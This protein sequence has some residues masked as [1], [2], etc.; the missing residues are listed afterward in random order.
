MLDELVARARQHTSVPWND[1]RERRLLTGALELAGRKARRHSIQRRVTLSG[2]ALVLLSVLVIAFV[3]PKSAVA[4]AIANHLE[5]PGGATAEVSAGAEVRVREVVRD[6]V[7]VLQSR[8]HVTYEVARDPDR[9]FE[10]DAADVRVIVHG[11]RFSVTVDESWVRVAVAT[12]RVE[13]HDGLR[14]TMLTNG[15]EIRV[16]GYVAAASATQATASAVPGLGLAAPGDA[17]TTEPAILPAPPTAAPR[18]SPETAQLLLDRADSARRERRFAEAASALRTLVTRYP[19]DRRAAAAWFTLGRI[20]SGRGNA[21]GAADAFA[22]CRRI[23]RGPLAEDALAEEAAARSSATLAREYL[24]DY[25]N[26]THRKRM[27]A[28]VAR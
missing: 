15:E 18:A 22:S 4:P 26:G 3:Q 25:P 19:S 8:G 13:V 16:H 9:R 23:G 5:L 11:T 12:G 20:E 6:W 27:Q 17:Q 24:A 2:S 21:V 7:R 28:I 14:S 1:L 10:V